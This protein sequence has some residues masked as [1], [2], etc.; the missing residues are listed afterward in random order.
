[1]HLCASHGYRSKRH[2]DP[3]DQKR[4]SDPLA[5]EWQ[6]IVSHPAIAVE[7]NLGLCKS[8]KW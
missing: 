8:S 5:L 2:H 7:Q 1:V 6:V 3:G 4:L